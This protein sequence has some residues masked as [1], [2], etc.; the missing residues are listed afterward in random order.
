ML[1]KLA[2]DFELMRKE[3]TP[4]AADEI[5]KNDPVYH[6]LKNNVN[7][8]KGNLSSLQAEQEALKNQD[9][10][11]GARKGSALGGLAGAAAGFATG[12]LLKKPAYAGAGFGGALGL[13]GGGMAGKALHENTFAGRHPDITNKVHDAESDQNYEELKLLEHV[14]RNWISEFDKN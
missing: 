12:K 13:A 3:A 2:H 4:A 7:N 8:Y 1:T 10:Q 6:E 9:A 5:F 14:G 11:S